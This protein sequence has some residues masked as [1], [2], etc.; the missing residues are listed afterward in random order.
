MIAL[1]WFGAGGEPVTQDG[2]PVGSR[3][4]FAADG[5]AVAAAA[6]QGV[7]A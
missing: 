7:A 3:P 4:G 2:R 6:R 1:P 5:Y